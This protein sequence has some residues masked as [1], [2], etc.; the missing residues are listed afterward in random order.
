MVDLPFKPGFLV[1]VY[2]KEQELRYTDFGIVLRD[3][4]FLGLCVGI[5][6]Y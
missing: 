2:P 3:E 4:L 1:F 5:F 6:A